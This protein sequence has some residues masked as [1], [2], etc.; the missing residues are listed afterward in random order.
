MAERHPRR[1]KNVRLAAALPR[2]L[3]WALEWLRGRVHE[4]V[5]LAK[6]A[7][8]AGVPARTLEAHFKQFLGATPLGWVRQERLVRARRALLASEGRANVTKIALESGFT[9]LGRFAARYSRQF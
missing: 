4:P 2:D 6:L 5:Q 3:A 7:E 1:P 8:V 9:Q